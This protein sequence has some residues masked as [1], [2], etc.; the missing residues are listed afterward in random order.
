MN[1]KVKVPILFIIFNRFQTT[2]KVFETIRKYQPREL[3]I[4]ADGPR[5]D[6]P[7]EK[8]RCEEVKKIVENIDWLCDVKKL[9]RKNNLGCKLAVSGAIDWFFE[10]VEK[11]IIL[12]DDCLPSTSFFRFCEEMLEKYKNDER[13]FTISGDKFICGKV[14]DSYYFSRYVHLWGWATWR[15]A[16]K[17]Y[18][19]NMNNL[20]DISEINI[21]NNTFLER[22]FWENTFK[23][24]FSGQVDTWDYQWV[25]TQFKFR[26]LSI[27]PSTNLVKNIGFG[28]NATHTK[29]NTVVPDKKEIVFPLNH[30]KEIMVNKIF[31]TETIKDTIG[32]NLKSV[33]YQY[34]KLFNHV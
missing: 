24:V 25:Y 21:P 19:V 31:D 14:P 5:K 22:P 3:F 26:G 10:N 27:C 4:A 28:K 30:P 2:E 33:I 13:I 34:I 11:G 7:G 29:V 15:R 23:S 6:K 16:W 32:V 8:E 12:E 20:K 18:D 17:K 9:Y 1:T